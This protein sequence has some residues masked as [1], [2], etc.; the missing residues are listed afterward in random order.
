V[1]RSLGP[2]ERNHPPAQRAKLKVGR[3]VAEGLN[4]NLIGKLGR[5]EAHLVRQLSKLRAEFETLKTTRQSSQEVGS[6]TPNRGLTD[7]T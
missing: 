7:E 2:P 6:P 1:Y 4:Q 3:L 5:Y